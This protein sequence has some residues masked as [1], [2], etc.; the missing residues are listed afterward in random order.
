MMATRLNVTRVSAWRH[1][2]RTEVWCRILCDVI[3]IFRNQREASNWRLTPPNTCG[4]CIRA[5]RIQKPKLKMATEGDHPEVIIILW[6]FCTSIQ[7]SPEAFRRHHQLQPAP[8]ADRRSA[9]CSSRKP[10][11]MQ[12]TLSRFWLIWLNFR[13][14]VASPVTNSQTGTSSSCVTRTRRLHWFYERGDTQKHAGSLVGKTECGEI[15]SIKYWWRFTCECEWL[16]RIFFRPELIKLSRLS[17][18]FETRCDFLQ[19][20]WGQILYKQRVLDDESSSVQFTCTCTLSAADTHL[21][22]GGKKPPPF[23][24]YISCSTSTSSIIFLAIWVISGSNTQPSALQPSN[25]APEP[26]TPYRHSL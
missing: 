24:L 12:H 13:L 3:V 18:T 17:P 1:Q 15:E 22:S 2:C 20:L 19:M 4:V 26:L 8:E 21:K 25:L 7:T 16:N 9:K 10:F 14:F 5:P 23:T 6:C 11:L